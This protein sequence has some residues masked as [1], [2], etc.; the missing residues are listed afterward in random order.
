[1]RRICSRRVLILSVRCAYL[2]PNSSS[3]RVQGRHVALDA[4]LDLLLA[5]VYLGGRE[6]AVAAVDRLELTSVYSHHAPREQLEVSAQDHEAA[7]DVAD[8]RAVVAPEVGDGLEVRCQAA[9]QP[10]QLD[11]ALALMLQA[12][13]ALHP[14]QVAVDVDL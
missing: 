12:P 6:V 3:G 8:A 2:G 13:A 7:A 5:P 1:M 10:H 11:V 4:L 14:I 9:R